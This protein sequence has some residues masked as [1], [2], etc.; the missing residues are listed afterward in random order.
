MKYL[1]F[2]LIYLLSGCSDEDIYKGKSEQEKIQRYHDARLKIVMR[3]TCALIGEEVLNY[4]EARDKKKLE[5]NWEYFHEYPYHFKEAT[6]FYKLVI[7][8]TLKGHPY[9][10]PKEELD[11][12]YIQ[13]FRIEQLTCK[14]NLS[15]WQSLKSEWEI[16]R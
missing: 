5:R 3:W 8:D 7:E 2:C 9:K 12:S 4:K 10:L 1:F 16:L 15:E 11:I 14:E 6:I 13:T